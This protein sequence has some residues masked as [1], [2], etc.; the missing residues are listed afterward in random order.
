MSNRRKNLSA[1]G[2]KRG[3]ERKSRGA[4]GADGA[5]PRQRSESGAFYCGLLYQHDGNVVLHCV[6]PVALRTLQ[7]LRIL[8][9]I[10]RLLARGADQNLQQ[11]F[12]YHDKGIVLKIGSPRRRRRE[13]KLGFFLFL[14][15]DLHSPATSA[16]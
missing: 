10:E 3:E 6:H 7:A 2:K 1:K 4:A 9:V 5:E 12:G 15:S 14:G 11:F 13:R 16:V 8:P